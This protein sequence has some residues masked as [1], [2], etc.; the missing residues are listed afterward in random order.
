MGLRK[1]QLMPIIDNVLVHVDV[2]VY[3]PEE[4]AEYSKEKYSFLHSVLSTG[5]AVYPTG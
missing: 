3:T 1:N 5:I 2:H 4:V